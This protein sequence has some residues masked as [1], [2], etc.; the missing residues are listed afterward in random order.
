MTSDFTRSLDPSHW[1]CR[2]SHF[3]LKLEKV[4]A[5]RSSELPSELEALCLQ[6]CWRQRGKVD[7][8]GEKAEERAIVGFG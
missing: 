3:F 5:M 7:V 4:A 2:C 1:Q 8:F 6:S